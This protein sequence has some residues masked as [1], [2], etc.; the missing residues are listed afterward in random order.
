MSPAGGYSKRYLSVSISYACF[1]LS[2]TLRIFVFIYYMSPP[3][4]ETYIVLPSVYVRPSVRMSVCY[5][6]LVRA[7]SPR[8]F[9]AKNLKNFPQL[10]YLLKLCNKKLKFNFSKNVEV[11]AKKPLFEFVFCPGQFSVT[12]KGRDTGIFCSVSKNIPIVQR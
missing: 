4:G 2:A 9:R 8:T 11:L 3:A 1:V 7:I 10:T 12:I 5:A 6:T